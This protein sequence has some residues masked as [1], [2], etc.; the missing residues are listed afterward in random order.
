M[1]PLSWRFL[2]YFSSLFWFSGKQIPLKLTY[3]PAQQAAVIYR[4][5]YR[6]IQ[7]L[8]LYSLSCTFY[9]YNH[10]ELFI[11]SYCYRRNVW[12]V[13]W[14]KIMN[15]QQWQRFNPTFRQRE[16]WGSLSQDLMFE[17]YVSELQGMSK[18]KKEHVLWFLHEWTFPTFWGWY[19]C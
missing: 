16:I 4:Y 2:A 7:Y 9:K 8:A 11:H 13:A 19:K 5:Y 15:V 14:S 3:V 10:T 1:V 18:K 17:K 12:R 6:L